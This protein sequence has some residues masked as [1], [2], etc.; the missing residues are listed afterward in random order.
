MTITITQE[1]LNLTIQIDFVSN[2]LIMTL[3]NGHAVDL[4]SVNQIPLAVTEYQSDLYHAKQA[5]GSSEAG[6]LKDTFHRPVRRGGQFGR[7][8]KEP[9]EKQE[10]RYSASSIFVKQ[11][12]A[13]M[14]IQAHLDGIKYGFQPG[15]DLLFQMDIDLFPYSME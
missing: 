3:F 11:T 15:D 13:L 2:Q 8:Q 6:I 10:E 9:P 7:N 4:T 5:Q 12:A 1:V 14:L